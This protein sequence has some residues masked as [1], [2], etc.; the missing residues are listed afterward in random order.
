M[1]RG[2][3]RRR[4]SEE[5]VSVSLFPFLAV[6]IC[7]MGA[8]IV[9]LVVTVQQA[10]NAESG[11]AEPVVTIVEP[12]VLEP[13]PDPLQ[14]EQPISEL[15]ELQQLRED[16]AWKADSLAASR[17]AT[18][19]RLQEQQLQL[20]MVEDQSRELQTR[21]E[22]LR[23]E[24]ETLKSASLD[25]VELTENGSARLAQ[26]ESELEQAEQQLESAKQKA[27]EG[28]GRFTII[29]HQGAHGTDRRPLYVECLPD[30]VV[31]RPEGVELSTDDFELPMGPD[32]ALAASF[33]A[34]REYLLNAGAVASAAEPYPLLIVRPGA[35]RAYA[36]CRDALNGW[37]DDF[38]YE[39]VPAHVELVYPPRD[40]ILAEVLEKTI[41]E[42]RTRR[43]LLTVGEPASGVVLG[44]A[45]QG[46]GFAPTGD[47]ST[48]GGSGPQSTYG[49]GDS[50][51]GSGDAPHEYSHDPSTGMTASPAPPAGR[52]SEFATSNNTTASATD[53]S[54][55]SNVQVGLYETGQDKSKNNAA[56]SCVPGAESNQDSTGNQGGSQLTKTDGER[57]TSDG[58]SSSVSFSI[59]ENRGP[60]WALP[61][62]TVGAIGV[63]RPV[64]L[65]CTANQLI[66]Q[67]E[68][69]I[70]H[71]QLAIPFA[72]T[73]TSAM[74]PFVEALWVRMEAWGV[75]GNG[76]YWQPI[77]KCEVAPSG[78]E[79]FDEL[80][81]LLHGSGLEIHRR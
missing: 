53:N 56:L 45:S 28:A 73:T 23:D 41:R 46:G 72:N 66:L 7:T 12:V 39:L 18:L 81:A 3:S 38:G 70:G 67:P 61:N 57:H 59:A 34:Q 76:M 31:L 63:V 65:T 74:Q 24:V 55:D 44:I 22:R 51:Y 69:R 26:L 80:S 58:G 48:A 36:A 35:E 21:L 17:E 10:G 11:S 47:P 49:S 27:A 43:K 8:L 16:L 14:L 29:P 4:N 60:N 54:N 15:V 78:E 30:R 19:T 2:I 64:Y 52:D 50:P 6:L 13:D 42:V 9:L 68:S 20:S 79:R 1:S 33:R 25:R 71:G 37:D 62:D 77:L 75:A 5:S 32:N 40:A